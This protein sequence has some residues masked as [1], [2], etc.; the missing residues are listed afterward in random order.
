VSLERA[1]LTTVDHVQ[2]LSLDHIL[3]LSNL[4][5]IHIPV[6]ARPIDLFTL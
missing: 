2:I 3:L 6:P 4:P 1:I 5:S